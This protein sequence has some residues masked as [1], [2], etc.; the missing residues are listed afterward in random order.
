M[1]NRLTVIV[2]AA[3]RSERFFNSGGT[4]HK[5][6]AIL[7]AST[8]LDH[9]LLSVQM[10]G[11]HYHVVTKEQAKPTDGI[12]DS[13]A[14]GVKETANA[15][16]WLILPGDLPLVLPSSLLQVASLLSTHS[17]SLPFY[18][19]EQGH[20]VGF[21]RQCFNDLSSLRGDRG[22]AK[23]VQSHYING[24]VGRVNLDD[25]GIVLDIDTV[26]DLSLANKLLSKNTSSD[27]LS[28]RHGKWK[29]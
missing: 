25:Q 15:N 2:L 4:S 13:I 16:A 29:V 27:L 18:K 21:S 8:V 26:E 5:L 11:L 24:S 14:R 17:V 22:A 1:L 9:V 20:P 7:N 3:G 28:E 23:I 19:G 12:G 6:N 10:S